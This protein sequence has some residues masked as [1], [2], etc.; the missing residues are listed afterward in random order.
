MVSAGGWVGQRASDGLL[1]GSALTSVPVCLSGNPQL[2]E[3]LVCCG[4]S[5]LPSMSAPWLASVSKS[6]TRQGWLAQAQ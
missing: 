4:L 1:L 6:P 2:L 5:H 3:S